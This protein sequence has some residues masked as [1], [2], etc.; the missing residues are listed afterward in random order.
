M[1]ASD[2]SAPPRTTPGTTPSRRGRPRAG[3]RADREQAVLDAALAELVERGY[4]KVTMLGVARRAGASKE[5]IYNWFGGRDGVFAAV[6]QRNADRSA[7]QVTA[8][9]GGD[10]DPRTT[11]VGYATGWLALLTGDASIALNRAAMTSPEL[12]SLLLASGRHRIGP[13][14][15]EYLDRLHLTGVLDVPDRAG[16]FELLYGLVVQDTQIR[17]LLGESPPSPSAIAGRAE[18]AVERFFELCSKP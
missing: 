12:A 11:L 18:T 16:A 6:I 15:E 1:T 17:V 2:A 7:E 10:G 8:A 3:E 9:L 14:V 5:T 4:D 13:V